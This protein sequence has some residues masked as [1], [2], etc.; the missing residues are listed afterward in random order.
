MIGRSLAGAWRWPRCVGSSTS[1]A[2]WPWPSLPPRWRAPTRI[3]WR[4]CGRA[5]AHRRGR[6]TM[7]KAVTPPL[8]LAGA[9]LSVLLLAAPRQTV[10]CVVVPGD[11]RT[12]DSMLWAIICYALLAATA[13][14]LALV[15]KRT[16]DS[17]CHQRT[18]ATIAVQPLLSL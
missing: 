3:A 7:P 9:V 4:V 11:C 8:L 1:L 18:R 15:A 2:T 5:A 16:I 13:G 6:A 12:E 17:L 14:L 10:M